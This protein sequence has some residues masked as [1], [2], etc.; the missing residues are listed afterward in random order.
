MKITKVVSLILAAS[1]VLGVALIPRNASAEDQLC[2]DANISDELKEVAGC[3]ETGTLK[4]PVVAVVNAMLYIAGVLSVIMAIYAGVQMTLSTGNS[5]KVTKAKNIL[6]YA[7]AGLAI[8][9]LAYVIINF[10]VKE[11]G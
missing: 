11:V 8:S 6:I 5:G 1:L 2:D 7:I 9:I 4:K 3:N 10:V